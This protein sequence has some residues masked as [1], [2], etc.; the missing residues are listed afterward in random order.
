LSGSNQHYI[1]Q[2]FLRNFR[3]RDS[4]KD[5][6]VW[7]FKRGC[8][9]YETL[10]KKTAA[11]NFF[12]SEPSVDGLET[13][14]DWITKYESNH[15]GHL[16]FSLRNQ[17]IGTVV[18]PIHAAEIIT[19]LTCRNAYVR[20][21]IS[22]GANEVIIGLDKLV[23]NQQSLQ[24]FFS[25]PRFQE[26]MDER[27][28]EQLSRWQ[29][30]LPDFVR[31][32]IAT[33]FWRENFDR[34][35]TEIIPPF[36]NGLRSLA[37]RRQELARSS[38]NKALTASFTPE[39]RLKTLSY[40]SWCVC[41][42]PEG[43]AILPDCVALGMDQD[44]SV[45]RPYLMTSADKLRVVIF[46]INPDKL[47]IG[48]R[49]GFD[50]PDL[51]SFNEAAA[52]CSHTF[53]VSA[54]RT[55]ELENL[56]QRIGE[57]SHQTISDTVTKA[58]SDYRTDPQIDQ[59]RLQASQVQSGQGKQ[60][61]EACGDD[62]LSSPQP[63]NF[64]ISFVDCADQ[65]TAN[66]IGS[67]IK[68]I[69]TEL[70]NRWMPLNRLDGITLAA[71]YE[72]ALQNL[73]RGV[74][75]TKTLTP[76]NEDYGIGLLI[77]VTVVRDDTIKIRIVAR[78]GLGYALISEEDSEWNLAAHALVFGLSHAACIELIEQALPGVLMRPIEDSY[79]SILYPY[80]DTAWSGYFASRWSASFV[81][82]LS[83]NY[84]DI[85]I[86]V[87][88]QMRRDVPQA[89]LI[90]RFDS[91]LESLLSFALSSAGDI[92]KYA[93]NLLGHCDAL[94]KSP[95][96]N[97]G[98]LTAALESAGLNAWLAVFQSDLEKIWNTRGQWTSFQEFLT[99]NRHLE[100]LLWQSGIFP[101]RTPEG[102]M[103]V[104]VPLVIDGLLSA[105]PSNR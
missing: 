13:L 71:D 26:M 32:Q 33:T 11:E 56:A 85:L 43:G 76:M 31:Q 101:Y 42:A 3:I 62:I 14:D 83:D 9:P 73:D 75:A 95:Y 50:L 51:R 20:D 70:N 59:A 6:K 48:Y 27:F 10:I 4:S 47:L 2:S 24:A 69:V 80:V 53:F 64:L 16:L 104:Q 5:K 49:D 36:T 99:L 74:P 1:P 79:E 44:N 8:A 72:H 105:P 45:L 63:F 86:T 29:V 54:Y 25:Q 100:R 88:E 19:H 52:A 77:P 60:E 68:G 41:A 12:Y 38:H 39:E 22:V 89:R 57:L 94:G 65:D 35:Y 40:L 67:A 30:D 18:D 66:V 84:R 17:N 78:G 61:A 7:I 90:Y 37:G 34:F 91:D 97:N 93:A 58:L 98:R 87:L 92:L 23:S 96:D 46:P 103:Y 15:F 55:P 21:F 82:D 28:A 81:P 102:G